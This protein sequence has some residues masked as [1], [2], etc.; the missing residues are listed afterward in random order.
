MGG[1]TI[2]TKNHHSKVS[3]AWLMLDR[4]FPVS[5][6]AIIRTMSTPHEVAI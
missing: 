5:A 4:L 6:Y 3:E 1:T 2:Q